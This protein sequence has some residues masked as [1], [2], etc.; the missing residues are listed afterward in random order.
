MVYSQLAMHPHTTLC[1]ML[2]HPKGK[3]KAGEQ[4][5]VVYKMLCQ[6]LGGYIGEAGCLPQTHVEE[7]KKDLNNISITQYT[8][9][10]MKLSEIIINNSAITVYATRQNRLGRR[11]SF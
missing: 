9:N 3:V 4:G 11:H 2:V 8:R 5:E 1:R 7:H 10:N 6:C